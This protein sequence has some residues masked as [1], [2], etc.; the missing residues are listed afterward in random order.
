[1]QI[2]DLQ[3]FPAHR[4]DEIQCKTRRMVLSVAAVG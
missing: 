4:R 1:M 2:D 3:M